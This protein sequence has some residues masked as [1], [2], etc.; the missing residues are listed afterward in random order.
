MCIRDRITGSGPQDRDETI[1]DHKPF[2][3]IADHLSRNGIAV[4]RYD[5]R[6]VGASSGEFAGATSADLATDVEAAI[7]RLKRRK[8]VDATRI[9][10]AGHSEGGLLAP[11]I[12]SRRDDV[13]GV[14][15]LA[16]P[17]VNGAKIAVNQ[18]RLIAEASGEADAKE[19]E[20]QEKFLKIASVSYTH[21]TLPTICS[22]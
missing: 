15:L 8:D 19:L 16:P 13:A 5:E 11:M 7:D 4:L 18:S 17:G 1:L 10:L 22:V 3:V 9:I 6:G 21:L 20:G 12:A 14:I 2:A